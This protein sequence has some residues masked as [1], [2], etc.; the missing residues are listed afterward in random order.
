MKSKFYIFLI[1]TVL[2][3]VLVITSCDKSI[4]LS[5]QLTPLTP[6]NIDADA[7]TWT[8][9]F[10]T[11]PDQIAVPAPIDVNSDPYKAELATI[12][13]AQSKLTGAQRES[14]EY[15]SGGGVLRWNQI[16]RDLVSRYNLPP[17]P[18]RSICPP[19]PACRGSLTAIHI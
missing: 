16:F 9:V 15:W 11:S 7:A 12:K 2:L 10:M 1:S 18:R 3:S 19:R 17:A 5:E 13:D 8:M 4:E 6:A 14:I